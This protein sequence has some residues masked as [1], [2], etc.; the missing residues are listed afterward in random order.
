MKY[1][2]EIVPAELSVC[3]DADSFLQSGFW[4]SFKAKFGWNAR[5]FL[6]RW[7]RWDSKPLLVIRRRLGLGFSFAYVPWGPE[8]PAE[9]PPDRE[10]RNT[11]L[12]ELAEALRSLL[13]KN[14]GFIRFDPPWHTEGPTASPP[15]LGK[16]F[17]R[18]GADVQP[19]D[20]VLLD[21]ALPE[22]TLLSRMKSKCRYNVGLAEK[23]GVTVRQ[24][25]ETELARFHALL[26]ETARRDGIA[27][28]SL[29]YYQSL[30]SHSQEYSQGGQRTALY[31]AEHEGDLLAGVAVLFR[32]TEAVYLYGASS[33]AKRN[34]MAP[35]ALQWRAIRDA[36]AAG[37][38]VYDLFG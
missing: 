31:F 10:A 30:F 5:A 13:P 38:G 23:K 6:A 32:G 1:L 33:D 35:Y 27:V 26:Q 8:L 22:E 17:T 37:C 25:E 36:K 24:A 34:L 20:T 19:P 7:G 3:N 12:A 29:E 16:P 4:G 14:I 28:H 15:S 9:F 21:L 2:T 11:A 18:A